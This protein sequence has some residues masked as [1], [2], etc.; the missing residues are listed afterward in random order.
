MEKGTRYRQLSYEERVKIE[1]LKAEGKSV[2]QIARTLCR[3]PNTIAREWK[4]KRV[5]GLYQ[6]K[7]AQ[8]KT[9]WRRYR[10]KRNCMNVA[11]DKNL[12]AFVRAGLLLGWSPERI[13]GRAI[14]LG[15]P[16]SK[17]AVYKFIYSRAWERYLFWG[18][19]KRKGGPKRRQGMP[20]DP[21]KK[22]ISLRPDRKSVV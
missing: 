22:G 7:K 1:V 12:T 8:H 17:K 20:K 18:R 10:S 19:Y 21:E 6:P 9:Y 15:M 3:S 4:E 2:R 13:A 14:L 11:I 5:K 16:L